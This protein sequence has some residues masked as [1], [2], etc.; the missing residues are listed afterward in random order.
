MLSF[1]ILELSIQIIYENETDV[2]VL[3]L[4][5]TIN[6]KIFGLMHYSSIIKF[7][8]QVSLSCRYILNARIEK[9]RDILKNAFLKY[10]SIPFFSRGLKMIML[11]KLYM[12]YRLDFYIKQEHQVLE[13]YDKVT[14]FWD[15]NV[16]CLCSVPSGEIEAKDEKVAG[17]KLQDAIDYFQT[18]GSAWEMHNLNLPNA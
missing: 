13:N 10:Q 2:K 9:G 16:A 6:D 4:V 11:T 14:A 1:K 5:K 7:I 3:K 8:H 17:Y 18:N 15:Q 12:I